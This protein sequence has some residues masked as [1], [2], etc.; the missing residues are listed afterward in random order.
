MFEIWGD[1]ATQKQRKGETNRDRGKKK[2]V[3]RNLSPD[4]ITSA[5]DPNRQTVGVVDNSSMCIK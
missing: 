4:K 1:N 3:C 5:V 2:E